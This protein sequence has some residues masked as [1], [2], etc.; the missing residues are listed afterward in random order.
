M[1]AIST[2]PL[3]VQAVEALKVFNRE[4]AVALLR[5]DLA[6]APTGGD[7]WLSVAK[8]AATIGERGIELE[9]MRRFSE[10]LPQTLD[11]VLAYAQAL[12]KMNR[13]RE[14]IDILDGLPSEVQSH[15]AILHFRGSVFTEIGDFERAESCFRRTL[16][17]S[18]TVAQTWYGLSVIKTF[19]AGDP[20]I[21]LMEA[22]RPGFNRQPAMARSL[23]LYAL[24][25]AWHDAGEFKKAAE[26]Y[27]EGAA[28]MRT[29]RPYNGNGWQ[30]HVSRVIEDYTPT[31][32]SQLKPSKCDSNRV[33]FVT[34]LP[35]SGTT[36]VEQILT[37]HSAIGAGSEL[38]ITDGIM[39]PAGNFSL[40]AAVSYQEGANSIDPWGDIGRNYIGAVS[41]QFGNTG[42]IVDKTLSQSR[43]MGLLLH[44]LPSAKLI[45][46]RRNPEDNALSIFR[47][48]F[49][50]TLPWSW[51][52]T[53]IA[54]HMKEEDRL[55]NHW[56]AL[57]P[58]RILSVPY[59]A[60]VSDA[61]LWIRKILAH[62]N[63]SQ[64]IQVFSPHTHERSVTTASVAQV[65]NPI[66]T[67]RIGAARA[68]GSF[69]ESFRQTYNS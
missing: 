62:V 64:E 53:D 19:K 40:A 51:S 60:L 63:L 5:K 18:P 52:L 17:E 54:N 42:L 9:A 65:R 23:F 45:W 28:L 4:Y 10:T 39:L 26:I 33:I 29:E 49:R 16:V 37:S 21:S 35:R 1:T 38:N 11:H 22:V 56:N 48:H 36:L 66:N 34:G 6:T 69:M 12:S 32:L 61:P 50:N 20:D 15:P 43:L 25:K 3:V 46:L 41:A 8:L 30:T 27:D 44:A 67:T 55:Y 14:A 2:K 68:Y 58:D 59:E 31:A 24:A 57:F 47:T 7:R 13:S